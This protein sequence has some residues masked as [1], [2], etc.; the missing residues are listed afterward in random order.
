MGLLSTELTDRCESMCELCKSSKEVDTYIV[1]P[2]IGLIIDE[3]I[4][5]CETCLN[6]IENPEN[7]DPN[8]WR[9]LNDSMWSPISAVQ[10]MSYRMLKKLQDQDWAQD[11]LNMIYMDEVTREWADSIY[12]N[13]DHIIIHKDSNGNI[14]HAGDTVV[15]IKDLDVKGANFIAKRGTA[16]RRISLVQD[17]PEQIEGRVNDQHI[18]ILTQYIKKSM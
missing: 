7:L 14:L 1:A 11:L 16:V 4:A 10:V 13:T 8:H 2:K 12:Q 15:L 5:V 3:Q 18:V 17:N 9:C 6:Q